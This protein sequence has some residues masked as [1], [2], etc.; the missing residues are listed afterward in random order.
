VTRRALLLLAAAAALALAPFVRSGSAGS[1]DAAH[2]AA[3]EAFATRGTFAIDGTVEEYT[4]HRARV[5]NGAVVRTYPL[6][7]PLPSLVAAGASKFGASRAVATF[8]A[9]TLPAALALVAL[10]ALARRGTAHASDALRRD[11]LVFAVALCSTA[12]AGFGTVLT[13]LPLAVLAAAAGLLARRA[14]RPLAAGACFGFAAACEPTALVHTLLF[15][16]RRGF[17]A[18]A[19]GAA[20]PLAL[21]VSILTSAGAS[22]LGFGGDQLLFAGSFAD[23][24]HLTAPP[25]AFDGAWWDALVGARGT[26]LHL[27]VA[28]VAFVLL[29][30]GLRA[31]T[32]DARRSALAA[33][34][35]AALGCVVEHP[36]RTFV[37]AAHVLIAPLA[38]AAAAHVAWTRFARLALLLFVALSLPGSARALRS[39]CATWYVAPV[40]TPQARLGL[41]HESTVDLWVAQWDVANVDRPPGRERLSTEFETRLELVA[42]SVLDGTSGTDAERRAAVETL[43]RGLAVVADRFERENTPTFARPLTHYHL[44]RAHLAAGDAARAEQSLRTCLTLYPSFARARELLETLPRGE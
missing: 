23:L 24:A 21:H 26:L 34:L 15:A 7:P 18:Y 17:V 41:P 13:G 43:R 33:L 31:S 19:A 14:A 11:A 40:F 30:C 22:P 28:L 8:V 20:L 25:D 12:L 16:P 38:F 1:W 39:P 6:S 36:A 27:P 44:A 37:P 10:V 35:L 2:A 3:A 9:A 32:P 42:R 29:G 5:A 4:Q